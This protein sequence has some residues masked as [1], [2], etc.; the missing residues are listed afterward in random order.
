MAAL[1]RAEVVAG[2]VV[3]LDADGLRE[4]G[5]SRTNAEKTQK[6]DRAVAGEHS[7]LV[8]KMD[9]AAGVATLVPIF[10]GLAPGSERLREELKSG[11]PGKW[12]GVDLFFNKWQHW[13]SPIEQ[14][15]LHS[16]AEDTPVGNRRRYATTA[17]AELERILGFSTKN[18]APWRDLS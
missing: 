15:V 5:H 14:I 3:Q 2:T 10:S 8:L 9:S 4:A 18:R 11:Y 7:F 12:C 6:E 17:A 16:T 1:T 13:E